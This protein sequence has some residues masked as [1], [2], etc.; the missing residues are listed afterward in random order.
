MKC[1]SCQT[2]INS[3]TRVCKVCGHPVTLN[4]TLEDLYFSR[5]AANAPPNLVRKVRSAPYLAK[6]RRVVTAIMFNVANRDVLEQK[7]PKEE[8]NPLLNDALDRFANIIFQYEGTIAKLWENTVLA[9]FGAP[10]T[11]EDDAL[12]A[13]HAAVSILNDVQDYSKEIRSPYG[14]PMQLNMVLNTGPVL[15]GDIKSN[16]KFDFQSLENTLECMDF[17]IQAAIPRCEVILFEDTY[18]FVKPFIES[19][20]LDDISCEDINQDLYLW[21]LDKVVDQPKDLGQMPTMQSTSL[22]GRQKELDL[23]MELG[24]TVLAGLGRV[25]LVLGEPGIGKTRLVLEWKRRLKMLDSTNQPRWIEGAGL[26]FGRELAYHLLKNMLRSALEIGETASEEIIKENLRATL[27]DKKTVD[28]ENLYLFL[29]HFLDV[30][31]SDADEDRIHNMNAT[32]LRSQYLFAIRTF[33]RNLA[34]VQPLIIILEDLHWA[35]DSSIGLLIDLL[36]LTTFSPILFCLVSRP[37]RESSGWRLITAARDRF[38]PRLTEIEL[39]KLD[40]NESQVLVK[41]LVDIDEIPE[42][43][44]TMVLGKSEGNPY[45]IEELIRMLI[46]EGI[47]IRKNDRWVVTQKM[48]PKKIPDSLQGLLTARIDRLS[49]ETRLTLRVA[50]VIGRVFPERV[51]EYVL[52]QQTAELD[53]MEQMGTLESIGMIKVAQVNPELSYKFQHILLQ[54]AAYHSIFETDRSDLHLSVGKAL[55][56]LY[57][58]Q[59]ERLASQLAHHFIQGQDTQKAITYLDMAGH[60]AMD[61]FAHAE[62]E[63]YYSQALELTKQPEAL[64]HINTDLGE[65]LAQQG[66][67]REAI[68]A[69]E[70]AIHYHRELENADR[71]ARIYAWSARSAYWGYD[72]QRSLEICLE[73]LEAVKGAMESPDIAYLIHETGRAYLFNNQPEK[74]RSYT[75]QALEM[76]RRLD[77]VEVQAEAL[78]TI[79]ILPSTKTKQAIAALEK[80]VS[81]SES[82]N[83]YG[84]ASRAYI[85]LAAVIDNLGDIRLARDYRNRAIQL[86]NKAGGVSD[87][88]LINQSIANASLWLGD[89]NDA[90]NRIEQMRQISRQNGAYLDDNTLNLLYLEGNF[91]RLK[92]NFSPSIEIFSDLIDRSRQKNDQELILEANRAMAEVIL[93]SHRLDET[94]RNSSNLD[95]T[96][97]MINEVIQSTHETTNTNV[98][99][100]CLLSN[101]HALKGNLEEAEQALVIANRVYRNQPAM[102]DRVRIILAQARLETARSNFDKAIELLSDTAELLEKMEGRWWRARIWL[103]MGMIHLNR[104]DPEDIDQAQSLF[105]ESLAEFRELGVNYYPELI[106]DKLRELKR[107][108]H[109]QAVAHRQVNLELAEAGRVQHTF[110][111]R[112]SPSIFGYDISGALLPA[113]ETSGDFYDF[114]DLEDGKLGVV[115][116]DV[117]DKGAGAALYMAMSRTLIRTYA[118]EGKLPPEGVIQEVNRRILT[119]TQRGIFLTV[120]FGILDPQQGI[121]TYVN[122]GHNPPYLLRKQNEA[123]VPTPLQKTGTLVGIFEESRWRTR[124]IKLNPGD[125]LVLYTDGIT[126]AQNGSGG[127]FGNDRLMN[128]LE[129]GFDTSAKT[130]RNAIL[131]R[132]Q[133]FTGSAPRLDDISLIIISRDNEEDSTNGIGS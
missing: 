99:T 4:P 39:D 115:I 103:E 84:S 133:G 63:L 19:T 1:T 119:D 40:E 37:D 127:F 22:I 61:S 9:F 3:G 44:A 91:Y 20:R 92:G 125:V 13:V 98:A 82:H 51:I 47:L 118:V 60:V 129:I 116:A 73:G 74:A 27:S 131:E 87:E 106:V 67:H 70:N 85:N 77:A 17:A 25:G 114:I 94:Q 102:Q 78:A 26:A 132:V 10:I 7:I 71:L 107:I 112:H 90:Q 33:L 86:G 105:R 117:G 72:P 100:Q 80:A 53:L 110:I 122:A 36:S 130:F 48:D 126:E 42:V 111:P 54:D 11:H 62:A 35:D 29:A 58:E 2:T 88:L 16:L 124:T 56:K 95:I 81:I 128:T 121:F 6:E 113:R 50:S 52:T 83:L 79:G 49:P 104:S 15:I 55:E 5:L 65:A 12:R 38:G 32:E 23:L 75:Q 101:I 120:V 69:W 46:N 96:L 59:R 21:R 68:K 14:L 97:S 76:A 43:I 18:R 45:F 57:P 89:F 109:D 41:Q 31:L 64:A 8:L 66:K 24:E 93:E 34:N 30:Q 108:S 123:L 28:Q